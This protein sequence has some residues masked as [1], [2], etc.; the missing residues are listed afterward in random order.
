MAEKG[1]EVFIDI[2]AKLDGLEKGLQAAKPI[3]TQQGAK[4]GY[5]FGGKFSEQAKGVVGTIAGPMMAA[6]LAKA[7]ASVL[8]SDKA[9][10]DA[11]LDGLKTIPFVGAF[12]DLGSAIYDA[13]F[14]AADK[15]ADDLLA[16]QNAARD[17]GRRIAG[18]REKEAQAAANATTALMRERERLEVT[19]EIARTRARGDEEAA[20]RAEAARVKDEQDTELAFRMAEGISDLELNALL[21]LNREK[22]RAAEIELETRLRTI[23]EAAQKEREAAAEKA[24]QEAEAAQKLA[25]QNAARIEAAQ[26]DVRLLRLRIME[27][28]AAA[29]GNTEAAKNIADQRERAERAATREKALRDA[30]TEAEREALRERFKLEDELSTIQEQRAAAESQG[31]NRTASANTALGAF[32]FDAYPAEVQRRVQERTADATEK[33]AASI[34]TIGFQ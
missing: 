18:E 26:L 16:K 6:G 1:G 4:L 12:A 30:T 31:A 9:I 8:R 24:K 5:D 11:I 29:D 28:K 23:R 33:V 2:T 14:G 27:E 34:S 7:A 25:E 10:P 13:T 21:E 32:T 19:N 20:V 22:Q 17:T 3:A 15:A